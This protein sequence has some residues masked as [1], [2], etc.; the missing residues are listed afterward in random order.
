MTTPK[1]IIKAGEYNEPHTFESD[2]EARLFYA[3]QEAMEYIEVM[4]NEKATGKTDEEIPKWNFSVAK[5]GTLEMFLSGEYQFDIAYSKS[6]AKSK[7]IR[8]GNFICEKFNRLSILEARLSERQSTVIPESL[9]EC[10]LTKD[11]YK[12]IQGMSFAIDRIFATEQKSLEKFAL[13]LTKAGEGLPSDERLAEILPYFESDELNDACL[14]G[15]TVVRTEASAALAAKEEQHRKEIE[16]LRQQKQ[17]FGEFKLTGIGHLINE[18]WDG[19]GINATILAEKIN[20]AVKEQ[21]AS[22]PFISLAN[23]GEDN[24][25]QVDSWKRFSEWVCKDW[26][27]NEKENKWEDIHLDEVAPKTTSELFDLWQQNKNREG[28]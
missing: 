26:F 18:S 22:M 17:M 13:F 14:A 25:S 19:D 28:E 20:A 23:N 16:E 10:R 9:K 5:E 21:L 12:E 7:M 15:A 8:L 2:Q 27:F 11:E 3:Y 6:E 24:K 4:T 1:N